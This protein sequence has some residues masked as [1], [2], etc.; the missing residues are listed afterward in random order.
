LS[1]TGEVNLPFDP[2]RGPGAYLFRARSIDIRTGLASD[3]SPA[4]TIQVP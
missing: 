2:D 1:A 4:R 3:W